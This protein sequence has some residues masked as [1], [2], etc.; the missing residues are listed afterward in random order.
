MICAYSLH[1]LDTCEGSFFLAGGA[2][3]AQRSVECSMFAGSPKFDCVLHTFGCEY[4]VICYFA[5]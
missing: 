1:I 2:G 4:L 5:K 3:T